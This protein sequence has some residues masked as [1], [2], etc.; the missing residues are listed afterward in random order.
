MA[1]AVRATD[2]MGSLGSRRSALS[3]ACWATPPRRSGNRRWR[4]RG[5][6][7]NRPG[8]RPSRP[9]SPRARPRPR[10]S[11]AGSGRARRCPRGRPGRGRAP[12]RSARRPRRPGSGRGAGTRGWHRRRDCPGSSAMARRRACSAAIGWSRVDSNRPMRVPDDRRCPA[13]SRRPGAGPRCAALTSPS[14]SPRIIAVGGD[15]LRIVRI[16]G[17]GAG[18]GRPHLLAPVE[19]EG[20]LGGEARRSAYRS[21]SA[22][23]R[24]G[25]RPRRRF[26]SS[27]N[28]SDIGV[29]EGGQGIVRSQSRLGIDRLRIGEGPR[30]VEAV[31]RENAPL[32]IDPALRP[33]E[34]GG[35]LRPSLP[36]ADEHAPPTRSARARCDGLSGRR[37]ASARAAA[38]T[39]RPS[40]EG[41]TSARLSQSSARRD[42]GGRASIR[43]RSA[44]TAGPVRAVVGRDVK[45]SRRVR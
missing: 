13:R 39:A 21:G 44:R 12:C 37:R 43:S 23:R 4:R 26:R 29:G 10:P 9:G 35:G 40:R 31:G 32:S 34:Q 17:R 42:A 15:H 8:S 24:P 5:G 27:R 25:A 20:D 30:D 2:T 41:A 1:M 36:G 6:L 22:S 45:A 33:G 19:R 18:D 16:G 14:T 3:R 28:A 38:A 11:G 7:A